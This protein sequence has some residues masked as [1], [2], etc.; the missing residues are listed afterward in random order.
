MPDGASTGELAV[1]APSSKELTSINIDS[2]GG[3][4]IGNRPAVLSIRDPRLFQDNFSADNIFKATFG[5]SFGDL[6]FG[7]VL[8][9]GLGAPEIAIDLSVVGSLVGSGDLGAVDFVYIPEPS[10]RILA[11]MAAFAIFV[12]FFS[13]RDDCPTQRNGFG[14]PTRIL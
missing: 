14:L 12:R 13:R 9:A 1:D 5:E 11:A 3:K 7:N 6:S 4:F 10:T 2:A 8:P